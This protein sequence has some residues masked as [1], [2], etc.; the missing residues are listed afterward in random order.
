LES[1]AFK[2]V[3]DKYTN[4]ANQDKVKIAATESVEIAKLEDLTFL[5]K[6]REIIMKMT[7]DEALA[8]LIKVY[9]ID[10]KIKAINAVSDSGIFTIK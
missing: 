7:H 3:D 9:K 8:E 5:A 1:N 4:G 2:I 6:Q 10:S